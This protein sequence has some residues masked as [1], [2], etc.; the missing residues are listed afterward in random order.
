MRVAY[1]CADPGIPVF[2]Q[3]GCSL[4]VQEIIRALVI[5]GA[6]VDLF[7]VRVGGEAPAGLES[8]RVHQIPVA[9]STECGEREQALI[10]AGDYLTRLLDVQAPFD[11]VYERHALWSSTAMQWAERR[12]TPCILEVNAPLIQE[13]ATHRTLVNAQAAWQIAA[14]S[15]TAA[16]VVACVSRQVADYAQQ[17]GA[18]ESSVIVV[19]NGVH[20]GRFVKRRPRSSK[21]SPFTVGFLGSLR[22]WHAVD[23]LLRSFSLLC[24]DAQSVECSLVIVGDGPRREPLQQLVAEQPAAVRRRV[25][26]VGAVAPSEIPNWLAWFDA[27]V[28]PYAADCDCYFS[29]LKLFEYMAAGLPIV[30]ADSGQMSEVIV[31]ERNGLLYPPGNLDE[32]KDRLEL[33]RQDPAG[34]ERLGD[35]ARQEA[36]R[37]HTWRRRLDNM[38]DA[39]GLSPASG[40]AS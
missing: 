18:R 31:H 6:V 39:A 5:Q 36:V 32:L 35:T 19:P 40:V 34:A 13:Q 20:T 17:L 30:A 4:H 38:L 16:S 7:A 27:A 1:V 22:P 21:S 28:A 15:V 2:G 25:Q 37:E 8:V 24:A 23:D 9:K 33:L 29:P 14:Q 10:D 11:L 26:V 12:Q 3:K